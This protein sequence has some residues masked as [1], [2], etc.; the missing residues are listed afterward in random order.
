MNGYLRLCAALLLLN[1]SSAVSARTASDMTVSGLV[2]P[3][4]CTVGLSGSGII[5][6]GKISAHH[7]TPEAPTA[8][9]SEWLEVDINCS[10]PMLFA[11]I[12]MDSRADSSPT[13]D[14][15]YG[16]GKNPHATGEHLGWVGLA[17][18]SA[19]GDG[20]PM[21]S[22]V[23]KNQGSSWVPQSAIHPKTLMGFA[24][25]GRP[26]PEPIVNLTTRIRAD[27]T[28]QPANRL[29][30]KQEVPLDGSLVLDLRYL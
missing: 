16:L 8:L 21:Q 30:L 9:P 7:L 3:S 11:L 26:F 15:D 18:E 22:L 6:H 28:I 29:S 2:T 24:R 25:P 13:P 17:F 12:G 5:D 4:S 23:S 20:Q 19:Q 1:T 27:T 10:G 14:T